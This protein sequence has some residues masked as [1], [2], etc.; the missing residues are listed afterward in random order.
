M[1]SART[2]QTAT[3][4]ND[5]QVLVAGGGTATAELYDPST[6]TFTKTAS[7]S[8]ARTDATAT[9]LADGDVLVAGGSHD[10][11]QLASA[12]IYNPSTASWTPTGSMHAPRSGMTATLLGGGDVLI[13]GGGCNRGAGHCD[14]G[15]FLDS[16]RSAE[17]YDPSTGTFTRT[18]PM[19]VGRQFATATLLQDGDVLVAGGFSDCDDDA[20]EDTAAAELYHPGSGTWSAVA[21]L[22]K[23]REQ[24]TAT[25]LSNGQVL[26]AGGK[27]IGIDS[28]HY[29]RLSEAELYNPRSETWSQTGALDQAHSGATASLLG[30]GWVLLAGGGTAAAVVYQPKRSVW[31]PTAAMNTVHTDGTAT[32]LENGDVLVAG[33]GVSNAETYQAG[34]GPL[35]T[36]A[37]AA[38]SF[39]AREVGTTSTARTFRLT[40]NGDGGLHVVGLVVSGKHASD[41][42]ADDRCAASL[43]PLATCTIRVTFSPH[44]PGRRTALVKVIDNAPDSPQI[45]PLTG[46]GQGPN[47]WVPTSPMVGSRSEYAAVTL[48]DGDVLIAGGELGAEQPTATAE[49]FDPTTQSYTNTGS[50]SVPLDYVRAA[51]LHDGRVFIAGGLNGDGRVSSAEVYDPATATWSMTAPMND[52]GYALTETVLHNGSVLVTGLG[53]GTEAEVYNPTT[54]SWTDTPP[55]IG[56]G[57]F[58]TATLLPGG[59]VLTAGDGTSTAGLY[60]PRTNSWT[61]TGPMNVARS[62]ASA[63]RLPTGDVLIAGGE[64]S[65]FQP[66]ASAE[67]YNPSAGTWTLTG[68]QMSHPR[69][70]FTMVTTRAGNAMAIGGCAA[71]CGRDSVTTSTDVYDAVDGYW[72]PGPSMIQSRV[73]VTAAVLRDGDV[74]VAGGSNYCCQSYRTS[75]LY[76]STNLTPMPSSGPAG[77]AIQLRGHGFYAFEPVTIT[78]DG[79][80]LA[81]AHTGPKGGFSVPVVVPQSAIGQHVI[82]ARGQ[83]SFAF[84]SVL[85]TVT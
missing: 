5:G 20:C 39:K 53:D 74:V 2:G 61:A 38:V 57:L 62:H 59:D 49:L 33:G 35:V 34:R 69:S 72:F 68:N 8:V 27:S 66:L 83:Q 85:F 25:L 81:R 23:R 67:V 32:I 64:D 79:Q 17:L 11:R 73:G 48:R 52:I 77:K 24:S 30:N 26:V 18:A 10:S 80:P 21:D 43:P 37:P 60:D 6:R 51:L 3:L 9:L 31:V 44:A 50:L 14:A 54:N 7:M 63:V 40:N 75:E 47:A 46:Y 82:A 42:R 41:F 36:V 15:S 28:A 12:E 65:Q 55:T 45:E 4:L 29:V 58:G 13:A 16:L 71:E 19:S 70:L 84:A 78:W 56:V 22:V 76:T 1:E